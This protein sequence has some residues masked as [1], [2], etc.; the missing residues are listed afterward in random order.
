VKPK[1][2]ESVE[3]PYDACVATYGSEDHIEKVVVAVV[4][5]E[6]RLII[7]HRAWFTSDYGE[8]ASKSI[9]AVMNALTDDIMDYC[10]RSRV[11]KITMIGSPL[12]LTEL[13][14]KCPHCGGE[15]VR[16]PWQD[17]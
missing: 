17:G 10:K 7:D 8:E 2:R 6:R 1:D 5:R 11:G 3:G 12:P 15:A 9:E 14:A 4:D 13:K 16:V